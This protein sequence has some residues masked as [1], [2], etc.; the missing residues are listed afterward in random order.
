M[1]NNKSPNF[2][3]ASNYN[4]LS[5]HNLNYN[6]TPTFGNNFFNS[7]LQ[8]PNYLNNSSDSN[9]YFFQKKHYFFYLIHKN[10]TFLTNNNDQYL[11]IKIRELV[12]IERRIEFLIKL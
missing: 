11:Q 5:S 7:N 10:N 4:N 12:V 1:S 9:N 3:I 2:N 8:K 6:D